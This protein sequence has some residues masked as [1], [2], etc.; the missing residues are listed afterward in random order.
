M[1]NTQLCFEEVLYNLF[2][3]KTCQACENKCK[4][5]CSSKKATIYCNKYKNNKK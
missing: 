1:E 4:V 2:I 3:S 5:L